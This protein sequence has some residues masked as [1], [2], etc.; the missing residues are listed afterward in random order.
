M[1]DVTATFKDAVRRQRAVLGAPTPPDEV[2][3]SKKPR[4]AFGEESHAAL[5]AIR[6]TASFLRDTHAAYLMED[7]NP[8][9]M[10][11]AERDDIDAETQQFLTACTERIDKLKRQAAS[12][13][14]VGVQVNAH[15]QATLQLLYEQLGRVASVFDE[16]RGHRL[17]RAA[18]ARDQRLGAAAEA[19]GSFGEN[20]VLGAWS[21]QQQQ[22]QQ[23]LLASTAGALVGTA[24]GAAGLGRA[25]GQVGDGIGRTPGGGGG[26]S[27]AAD[28]DEHEVIA[29]DDMGLDA[30][31]KA[32]LE[33]ENEA[34][35][36]ELETMVDQARQAEHSMLEISKLSHLFATKVEQQ[37]TEVELL[38]Q[39]AEQTSENL[40]RGNAYLDSAAKHSRDFRL[41]VLSFLLTASF[42]LLFLD[43]YYD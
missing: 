25:R 22:T 12:H 1:T 18:E 34:L 10:S 26:G 21:Q 24:L 31:E 23:Q 6:T 15:R 17:R 42:S 11:D 36:R 16:H 3:L 30:S 2:L 28:W 35:Q 38:Y 43:W 37:N 33:L 27:V 41:L 29:E 8:N 5:Q 20:G 4:S 7:G 40:V 19:A 39:H 13:G 9:G 32:Q 14:D